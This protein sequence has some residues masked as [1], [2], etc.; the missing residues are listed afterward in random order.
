MP[1]GYA[2]EVREDKSLSLGTAGS[3]CEFQARQDD[4]VKLFFKKKKKIKEWL[5]HVLSRL[6]V[7]SVAPHNDTAA[8]RWPTWVAERMVS[9]QTGDVDAPQEVTWAMLLCIAWSLA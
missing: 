6:G 1:V 2:E 8:R 9:L 3:T 5:Q 4:I 7:H